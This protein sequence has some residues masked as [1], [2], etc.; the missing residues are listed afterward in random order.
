MNFLT[1]RHP[2]SQLGRIWDQ[3]DDFSRLFEDLSHF[4][5]ISSLPGVPSAGIS[6]SLDFIETEKDFI[7]SLEVPG[8]NQ[9]DLDVSVTEDNKLI[10]KGEKKYKKEEEKEEKHVSECYFGTFRREIPLPSNCITDNINATYKNGVVKVILPKKIE[11]KPKIKKI[12]IKQI[13]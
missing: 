5:G 2:V 11:N 8:I 3:L 1:K 13:E 10:I 4:H 7:L 9:S 6:P 12:D